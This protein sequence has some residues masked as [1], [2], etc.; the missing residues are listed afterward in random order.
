M[1]Q[2]TSYS[3]CQ[4][5]RIRHSPDGFNIIEECFECVKAWQIMGITGEVILLPD[6]WMARLVREQEVKITIQ[7]LILGR[8]YGRLCDKSRASTRANASA[9]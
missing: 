9:E 7:E 6:S 8:E 1:T 3:K 5:S 4:H 2:S